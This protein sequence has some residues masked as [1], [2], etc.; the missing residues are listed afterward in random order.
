M[1]F[2][3]FF[4]KWKNFQNL[5]CLPCISFSLWIQGK[6]SDNNSDTGLCV[7]LCAAKLAQSSTSVLTKSGFDNLINDMIKNNQNQ[8]LLKQLPNEITRF[9][10]VLSKKISSDCSM[11]TLV[12]YPSLFHSINEESSESGYSSSQVFSSMNDTAD[13]DWQLSK[14]KMFLQYMVLQNQTQTLI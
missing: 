2:V 14:K 10:L 6:L 5:T 8:W 7:A 4:C 9:M 11:N 1:I 12:I 3:P 13:S